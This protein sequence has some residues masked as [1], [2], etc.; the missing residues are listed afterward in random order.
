MSDLQAALEAINQQSKGLDLVL[1]QT[2]EDLNT[3]AGKERL[4]KWQAATVALLRQHAGDRIATPFALV[5]P[6]PSFTNDLVEEFQDDIDLYRTALTTARKAVQAQ[7]AAAAKAAAPPA[8][9]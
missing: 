9:S 4:F 5:K 1:K 6:G 2:L 3:V 8:A 7:I